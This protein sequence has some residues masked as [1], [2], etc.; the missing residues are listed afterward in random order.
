MDVQIEVDNYI[1]ELTDVLSRLPRD[2]I[3]KVYEILHTAYKGGKR[4]FTMGNG[5]HGSTAQHW[6]NDIGKHPFVSD[7]KDN[8]AVQCGRFPAMCLNNDVSSLTAWANDMGYDCCFS[9]QLAQ[10][11]EP[12][13]VVAGISGSGNSANVLEAFKVARE[14]GATTICLSGRD[15]G[16]AKAEADVC[17]IVPCHCMLYI[18]DLHLVLCH[19]WA[20]LLKLAVQS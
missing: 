18:E 13:D 2:D 12:G 4:L 14:N 8:M 5:G 16:K 20:Q 11:V 7:D 3:E 17:V 6:I 1:R 19:I 10:W 15:G 9:K